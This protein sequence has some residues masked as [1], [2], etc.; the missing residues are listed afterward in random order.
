MIFEGYT[1]VHT[2]KVTYTSNPTEFSTIFCIC[3]IPIRKKE[4]SLF[5]TVFVS[6]DI[7]YLFLIG[8]NKRNYYYSLW[9]R[10]IRHKISCRIFLI[11]IKFQTYFSLNAK[12]I[13]CPLCHCFYTESLPGSWHLKSNC[14]I[15]EN[16]CLLKYV[17]CV[18][19]CFKSFPPMAISH[20]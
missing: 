10:T 2:H 15:L 16:M 12:L 11:K 20:N 19:T 17:I 18:L 4:L 6:G 3:Q 14:L 1:N 7:P 13:L 5:N 8:T 9:L